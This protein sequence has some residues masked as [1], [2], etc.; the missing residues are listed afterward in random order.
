MDA[1][2]DDWTEQQQHA[3]DDVQK[4]F[5]P[6]GFMERAQKAMAD[7]DACIAEVPVVLTDGWG[8]TSTVCCVG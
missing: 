8:V 7:V 3:T 5:F 6:K 2:K 1:L 4:N